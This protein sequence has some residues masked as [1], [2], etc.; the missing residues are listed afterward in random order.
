MCNTSTYTEKTSLLQICNRPTTDLSMT[1][2]LQI[3]IRN[4]HL[5]V[6]LSVTYLS[7][8]SRQYVI[9]LAFTDAVQC[10]DCSVHSYKRLD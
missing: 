10:I 9:I 4:C 8:I 5:Y 3:C 6:T 2:Q 1:D 7:Q